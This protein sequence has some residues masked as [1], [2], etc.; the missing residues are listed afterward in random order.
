[1]GQTDLLQLSQ[2]F[3]WGNV[4]RLHTVP[5]DPLGTEGP[6]KKVPSLPSV[7]LGC[8]TWV[9]RSSSHPPR[10]DRDHRRQVSTRLDK[11]DLREHPF[12]TPCS[13]SQTYR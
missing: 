2:S 9:G 10:P 6:E 7:G 12:S 3:V 13:S 4:P 1:M 5:L 11:T 8:E